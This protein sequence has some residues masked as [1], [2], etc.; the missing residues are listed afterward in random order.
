MNCDAEPVVAA[1]DRW[2]YPPN[3]ACIADGMLYRFSVE[4]LAY[5]HWVGAIFPIKRQKSLGIA[6]SD[7]KI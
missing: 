4:T 2:R 7:G 1:A 6:L 5:D 3:Q